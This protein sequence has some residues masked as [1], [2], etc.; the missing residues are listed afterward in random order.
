MYISI[1]I[2][3]RTNGGTKNKVILFP[4]R[5]RF[6]SCHCLMLTMLFKC[7]KCKR[8]NEN[9]ASAFLCL[10]IRFHIALLLF[11]FQLAR[12]TRHDTAYL[13]CPC[14]KVNVLPFQSHD[15][16]A[17]HSCSQGKFQQCFYGESTSSR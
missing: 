17:P 11:S 5:T 9:A 13:Q 16:T 6:L 15:F 8:D 14:L 4:K 10:C 7:C 2:E 3:P 1:R 12:N